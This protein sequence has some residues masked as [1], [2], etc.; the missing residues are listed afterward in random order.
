MKKYQPLLSLIL[1]LLATAAFAQ[2]GLITGQVTDTETGE[3]LPG[4]NVVIDG[5]TNGTVT[6]LDGKYRLSLDPGSY[7]L[8]FSFISFKTELR[9]DLKVV[10]GKTTAINNVSLSTDF[11]NLQEVV[12]AADISRNNEMA[13]LS[14]K[15]KSA[16][17]IDALSSASFK[18]VGDSDA[19]SSVKRVPGVSV[20][21]GK[22]IYVRGLSDRYTKTLLNGFEI[23]GLDPD[24][25]TIQMDLFPT[26]VLDNIVVNKTFIAPLP[27]DFTGGAINISTKDFPEQEQGSISINAG[28]NPQFH[29]Q[30]AYLTYNGGNTDMLGFDDGSRSIPATDNIPQFAEV[31]GN[32]EGEK[33][34]RYRDVMASFNP[35]MAAFS[36]R[37]FMDYGFGFN[38]GNQKTKEKYTLGYNFIL[39]YKNETSFYDDVE[40]GRYGLNA[41]PE[42]TEL[43][44]REQQTGS[45]GTNNV[46]LSGMAGFAIKTT[47]SKLK[48]NLLHLQNGESKAG[49]FNYLNSDQGAV[50]HGYQHNLEYSQRSMTNFMVSGDHYL[51]NKWTITWGISPTISA[52]HDP[53]IRFTRYELRKDNFVIGTEAGFPQRIWRDLNEVSLSA[54]AGASKEFELFGNDAKIQ[55][56]GSQSYKQRDYNIRNFNI[57]VR[58]L[59]LTGNPNELFTE[60]NLWLYGD[61]PTAGTTIDA[62]FLPTNPNKFSANALNTAAYTSINF[63]ITSLLKA[64]VGLRFENYL[65]RYTGQDQL[66][67]NILENE[68]VLHSVNLF[69]SLNLAYS[70]RENQ[71]LRFSYAKTIA[72]PSLKEVSY[73]EIFDPLTGRTFIG[74]LF[75]DAN[76]AEGIEY[77]NGELISTDI[78]NLD[79]RWETFPSLSS[80]VSFGVFYKYFINPIEIVQFATQAGAFQPRNVGDGQVLGAELEARTSL[81]FISDKLEVFSL[82]ANFTATQSQIALSATE[83]ESRVANARAGQTIDSHRAMAGQA[84]LIF[85]A[86]ISFDGSEKGFAKNLSLGL[87]YNVQ[88]STLLYVG[89]VDRPDIYSVAFHSLNGNVSK[90][91]GKDGRMA[92]D[93]KVANILGSTRQE[94]FRPFNAEDQNFSSLYAGRSF[95]LGFNYRF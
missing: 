78:H 55:F 16:N 5:T 81:K 19:A 93:L 49:I 6:D 15:K 29:F 8:R 70:I 59:Q 83:Y 58:G 36:G 40:Y 64:T 37:S 23:S 84:P 89:I 85:N 71:N 95:S 13:M 32:P 92:I 18:K 67:E 26:S 56:G 74:S 30:N 51:D 63:N 68:E 4:V 50:F 54:K 3:T 86:G 33:A 43:E 73:A 38:Y 45:F 48:I 72:R 14:M 10:A 47:K 25:N 44:V 27:A 60:E 24:R 12:I 41:N 7:D 66:G 90:K 77:W 21:D 75:R 28:Y 69:P 57:N 11:E 17:M 62:I 94:V 88:S 76:D 39:S 53:D 22:Y 46:L 2:Q 52:M 82:N 80:T 9:T 42:I 31:V 79:L 1:V 65:Q 87:F 20:Q 34:K 61:D 91:F 35:E